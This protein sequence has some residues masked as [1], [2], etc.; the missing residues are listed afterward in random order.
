MAGWISTGV[1]KLDH[2]N[3]CLHSSSWN[4]VVREVKPVNWWAFTE[5][6]KN[7]GFSG[8]MFKIWFGTSCGFVYI[9]QHDSNFLKLLISDVFFSKDLQLY[10]G[11]PQQTDI[12]CI[13][14]PHCREI[15][16]ALLHVNM[17][18]P[19][20]WL[21]LPAGVRAVARHWNQEF[22]Q[23]L[24]CFEIGLKTKCQ[25]HNIEWYTIFLKRCHIDSS[26]ILWVVL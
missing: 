7:T 9:Q 14:F 23:K 18:I 25:R 5:R 4:Q 22:T 6:I 19:G 3:C 11:L 20:T 17:K 13:S 8:F 12:M 1:L 24:W 10:L 16:V 21:A 26:G 2:V 15:Q